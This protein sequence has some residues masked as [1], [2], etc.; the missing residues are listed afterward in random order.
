[1]MLMLPAQVGNCLEQKIRA[2]DKDVYVKESA[3]PDPNFL[4]PGFPQV[5]CGLRGRP[6]RSMHD[7]HRRAD[8][9]PPG[10]LDAP[11]WGLESLK[12]MTFP[13]AKCPDFR[14]ASPEV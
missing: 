4:I 3:L 11:E 8:R 14:P 7:L 9:R 1:M 13:G 10:V 2:A 12:R 6:P 5:K